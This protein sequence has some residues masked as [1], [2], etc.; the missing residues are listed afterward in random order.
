MMNAI[1]NEARFDV[2]LDAQQQ[3]IIATRDVTATESQIAQANSN[4]I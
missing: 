1:D 2:N 4:I 3:G